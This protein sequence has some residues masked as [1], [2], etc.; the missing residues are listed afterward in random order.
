MRVTTPLLMIGFGLI[1]SHVFAAEP[2]LAD[3]TVR[4]ESLENQLAQQDAEFAAFR[5]QV[6]RGAMGRSGE[7]NGWSIEGGYELTILQPYFSDASSGPGFDESFGTGHRF[8]LEMESHRGY[9][10]RARYWM[11]RHTL[12][13][14]SLYAGEE[15]HID[16]D[17]LDVE[18]TLHERFRRWDLV[19][20]AG[21]RYGRNSYGSDTI[22][23]PGEARFEGVG[24][25]FCVEGERAI[26]CRGL[27]L[28]GSFRGSMLFGDV[29]F[30]GTPVE[31]ELT[32]VLDNQLGIGWNRCVGRATLDV[33][34]V[35]ESQFWWSNAFADALF[36]LGTN[37]GFTGPTVSVGLR[38]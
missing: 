1:A 9:G 12:D 34:A 15:L 23:G 2:S 11:Y 38:Y 31:D 7:C 4:I 3:L 29:D 14:H 36:G 22:F 37:L 10:A 28:I 6:S 30:W 5:T 26:G 35:W 21:A 33:R 25:T 13:G 18:L 16:M 17:A 24:P 32:A 19:F 20:G 8:T 27:Y